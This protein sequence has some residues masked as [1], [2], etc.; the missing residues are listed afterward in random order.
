[1]Y[2]NEPT[3]WRDCLTGMDRLRLITNYFTR[4]RFCTADG[5]IEL[6]HKTRVAP[7]GFSPWFSFPRPDDTRILFGHWAAL[8]GRADAD[9]ALALDTGCV[10][11]RSLTAVRLE[12]ETL[13]T[14]PAQVHG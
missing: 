8:E 4:L 9:F 1:M 7:P 10:W 2:G 11:G 6:L 5:E 14:V 3:R 12:D 13:F